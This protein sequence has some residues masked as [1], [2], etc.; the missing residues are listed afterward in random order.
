MY[1][2]IDMRKALVII[3]QQG[4]QDV[5]LDG[6]RKGLEAAGFEV[7]L[8]S[9]EAGKCVGKFGGEEVAELAMRDVDLDEFDRVAFIGGPGA[10]TLADDADALKLANDAARTGRPLGAICIAPTILAKAHVL[11]GKRA[12]A[13]NKDGKPQL[14]LEEYGAE[15]TDELVTRDDQILTGNGPDAAI[16]FGRMLAAM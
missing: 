14:L 2:A 12:T 10:G 15:F 13:W 3:A 4:F 6:T 16:E 8:A 11:D 5:E 1:T 7:V 9:K